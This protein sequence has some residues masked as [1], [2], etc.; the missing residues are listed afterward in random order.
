MTESMLGGAIPR[1]TLH[2][3]YEAS[4]YD[5]ELQTQ[6]IMRYIASDNAGGMG[7]LSE[8]HIHV[9]ACLL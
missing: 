4:N 9:T 3:S 8:G 5:C 2:D 7:E 1:A 6:T